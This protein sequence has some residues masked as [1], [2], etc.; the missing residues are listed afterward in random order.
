M[1]CRI[2][3]PEGGLCLRYLLA[4]AAAPAPEPVASLVP[5]AVTPAGT[6]VCVCVCVLFVYEGK[7]KI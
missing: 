7:G 1:R 3:N 6:C 5:G 2:S 4:V